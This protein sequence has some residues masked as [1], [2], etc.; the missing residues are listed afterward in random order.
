MQLAWAALA[1]LIATAGGAAASTGLP[2]GFNVHVVREKDG[3]RFLRGGA[4]RKDTLQSLAQSA[5]ARGVPVTLVDLRHPAN[6]DDR[7][8][9]GGRLS[10]KQEEAEARRLGFRYVSV[11]ALSAGLP[12]RLEKLRQEGDVYLHCM[13]GVNRT[14]FAVARYAHAHGTQPS[15][16]GLGKRDWRQGVAHETARRRRR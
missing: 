15:R 9:K 10:P 1:A 6:G 16:T 8:G 11:S 13:Y 14:G 3:T 2:P 5:K 4:P 12:E 7:S